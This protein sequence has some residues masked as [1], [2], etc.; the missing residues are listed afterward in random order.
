MLRVAVVG[1]FNAG[2]STFINALLRSKL[3]ESGYKPTTASATYIRASSTSKKTQLEVEFSNGTRLLVR[4]SNFWE[5]LF[6]CG[7]LKAS[8]RALANFYRVN[9]VSIDAALQQITTDRNIAPNVRSVRIGIPRPC[10]GQGRSSLPE[11]V[12]I[13][14]TPGFDPGDGD[15]TYHAEVTKRV[16]GNE[17]DLAIILT[18]AQQVL[19]ENVLSFIENNLKSYLQRCV[20]V[21]T[22]VDKLDDE[23]D[24][25]EVV[26]VARDTLRKR[27][28]KAGMGVQVFPVAARS[29]LPVKNIGSEE[30]QRVRAHFA[31]EFEAFENQLWCAINEGKNVA[32]QEHILRLETE[33]AEALKNE[34]SSVRNML[35]QEKAKCA[36]RRPERIEELTNQLKREG[37]ERITYFY[38]YCIN[39]HSDEYCQTCCS[40][41]A[42]YIRNSGDLKHFHKDV[43]PQIQKRVQQTLEEYLKTT[44]TAIREGSVEVNRILDDFKQKLDRHYDGL[45]VKPQSIK[46]EKDKRPVYTFNGRELLSGLEQALKRIPMNI[47]VFGT[48]DVPSWLKG[49]TSLLGGKVDSKQYQN[50]VVETLTAELKKIFSTAE[51]KIL[52]RMQYFLNIQCS[53]IDAIATD[54]V[55]RYKSAVDRIIKKWEWEMMSISEKERKLS[56]IIANINNAIPTDNNN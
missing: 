17:A 35:E 26:S 10:T 22:R 2:K 52:D 44:T 36:M 30:K 50:K 12:E 39:F 6:G 7:K 14:D 40:V 51:K 34:L 28:G 29:V 8:P 18:P 1:E 11:G 25:N 16:V 3:L 4:E 13:I 47:P 33:L 53:Y 24:V 15:L 43:Y 5:R 54:H 49:V 55:L 27:F 45:S 56:A 21:I 9:L 23:E 46:N 20:V 31:K 37:E 42:D 41:C 48:K 32:L 19:K 38:N